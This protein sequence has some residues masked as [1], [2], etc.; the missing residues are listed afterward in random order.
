MSEF[1]GSSPGETGQQKK[2]QPAIS[3]CGNRQPAMKRTTD[4]SECFDARLGRIVYS[5]TWTMSTKLAL[6]RL[7]IALRT[8]RICRHIRL[9]ICSIVLSGTAVATVSAQQLNANIRV[10]S[11][12][13]RVIVEGSSAP[14]SAWSFLDSYASVVGLANRIER[15]TLFDE[16]GSEVQVR[17]LAPGQF[18]SL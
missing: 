4:H 2:C 1:S 3:S 10:A 15:F 13:S 6:R 9:L 16:G 5:R 11:D 17:K 12:F 8:Q 18:N 7:W 14:A